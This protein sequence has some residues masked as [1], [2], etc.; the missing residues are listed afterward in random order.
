MKI[1]RIQPDIDTP[2]RYNY[3]VNYGI[4]DALS[5]L[6][7]VRTIKISAL[8]RL[9]TPDIDKFDIVLCP[10]FKRWSGWTGLE[11]VKQSRAK[12][13]LFDNDS[14]YRSFYD[15]FY[16]GFDFVFFRTVDK[17]RDI[18]HGKSFQL[19]WSINEKMYL[20]KYG[21]RGVSFNC[22]VDHHTYGLRKHIARI[23]KPTNLIGEKYIEHLQNSAGAI[24]TDSEV[25]PY[26]RAKV[27]E[28]AAC[29][30]HII[31]NHV[32]DMNH[33]FP[34]E[35]ID[36]FGDVAHLNQIIEAFVPDE[37]IQK[38]A[39]IHFEENH[40]NTI[41]AAQVHQILKDV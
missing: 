16:D 24:H 34:D 32:P 5:E 36:Y 14:C 17:N 19:R 39:R 23:K 28:F 1:L 12:A 38:A 25:M 11:R 8:F 2:D 40:T 15:Q 33:Y 20:P 31:S 21:G 10:M 3:H 9:T 18:P 29:G 22:T 27:L 7:E 37:K 26:P 13:V 30:T 41:R 4:W 35:L 6:A